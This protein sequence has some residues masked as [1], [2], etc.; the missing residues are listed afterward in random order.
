M[1]PPLQPLFFYG[2]EQSKT[3]CKD[4]AI[5]LLFLMKYSDSNAPT[6]VNT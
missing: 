3:Y 5:N 2:P 6:A 4:K 1:D